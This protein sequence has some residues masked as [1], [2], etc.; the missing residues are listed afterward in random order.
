MPNGRHAERQR[1][2]FAENLLAAWA[3]AGDGRYCAS[4]NRAWRGGTSGRRGR[5]DG[6]EGGEM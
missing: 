6:R 3:P 1:G 4:W 2:P 5:S